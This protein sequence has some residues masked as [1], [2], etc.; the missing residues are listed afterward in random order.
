MA[1]TDTQKEIQ[2]LREQLEAM[3]REREAEQA[4]RNAPAAEAE[5]PGHTQGASSV[6]SEVAGVIS[7][8]GAEDLIGQFKELLNSIDED[9]KETKPTTLLIVFA[10]GVLVGRL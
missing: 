6:L 5:I 2:L 8:N 4:A 7:D 1:N 10:L 9:I 3:K